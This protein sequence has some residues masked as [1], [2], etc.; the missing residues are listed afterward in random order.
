MTR[1]ER[2]LRNCARELSDFAR[3][4]K[5]G[6]VFYEDSF[7]EWARSHRADATNQV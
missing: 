7:R 3:G 4:A 1:Y 2:T 6:A 5:A